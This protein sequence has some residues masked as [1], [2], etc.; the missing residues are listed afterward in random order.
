MI[1]PGIIKGGYGCGYVSVS[2]DEEAP[3]MKTIYGTSPDEEPGTKTV[4]GA[5]NGAP[6]ARTVRGEPVPEQP[7]ISPEA[8]P[9]ALEREAAEEEPESSQAEEKEDLVSETE[10]AIERAR[11]IEEYEQLREKYEREAERYVLRA[12][13]KA[14]EIY[15]KTKE[16]AGKTVEEAREEAQKI[17][18][19]S[20][21]EGKKQGYDEGYQK[22]H[23]EGYVAA[24]KK[25]K[26]TLLE[27]KSLNEEIIASK[28]RLFLEY[29]HALF[30]SIFTIAQKITVN[31]LKQKDKAVI[32]RMLR[33]A[34]KRYRS[35]KNVK[36]TLSRLDI[37][38]ESE[39]DEAL[40]KEIFREGTLVELELVKDA[41]QGTL[42][43]DDGAEITD[44]GVQTQLKMIEQLGKR[45]YRDQ[46]LDDLLQAKR[47]KPQDGENL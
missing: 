2:A 19:R 8:S 23:E 18:E 41:P 13:E 3:V 28:E 14:A 43:L 31:S 6:A 30:D 11:L 36:I 29:E 34:A 5:H 46:A 32:T 35:S 40:L 12:K 9:E 4:Y 1:L 25:C 27:L 15:E 20:A 42:L 33:E 24:L 47:E 16:I 10:A 7:E 17:K 39:I 45:K 44:A 38:E 37:S 26:D 22:G 21:E